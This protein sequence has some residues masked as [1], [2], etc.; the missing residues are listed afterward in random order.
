MGK[1][2]DRPGAEIPKDYRKAIKDLVANQGWRYRKGR[3]HPILYP[4]D[5]TKNPIPLPSTASDHRS[6]RN[7]LA[8]IRRAGGHL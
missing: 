3:K 2:D 1:A 8:R 7:A 5:K 6:W 4:A